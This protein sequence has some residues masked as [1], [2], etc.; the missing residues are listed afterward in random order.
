LPPVASVSDR[1]VEIANKES[2]YRGYAD[3]WDASSLSWSEDMAVH[4]IPVTQCSLPKTD[5]CPFYFNLN[6][7]WYRPRAN[8]NTF[9]LRDSTSQGVRQE[10]PET[11]APYATYKISDV[12]TMYLFSYDV[13]SRF[14]GAP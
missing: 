14:V 10:L 8:I 3:Y 9:V 5:L 13:A 6:T 7:D 11:L 12:I 1:I 4:V 2:A